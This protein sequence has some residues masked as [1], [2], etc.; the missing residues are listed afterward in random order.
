MNISICDHCGGHVSLG[1]EAS[2][3]CEVCGR[4][5]EGGDPVPPTPKR[6]P[7]KVWPQF[8]PALEDGSK[9]F[10]ARKDDRCFRVG[11]VLDLYGFAPLT[12]TETGWRQ[13]R[14]ITYKLSGPAW[15]VESGYC[16]LGL[17]PLPPVAGI[18]DSELVALRAEVARIGKE[19]E[20]LKGIERQ[21]WEGV[22]KVFGT[23]YPTQMKEGESAQWTGG[24]QSAAQWGEVAELK[25]ELESRRWECLE[26]QQKH[27]TLLLGM[28]K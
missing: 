3:C 20:V 15:G 18:D 5:A 19:V 22:N 6:H 26:W 11:D 23:K 25:K 21:R 7:L 10:E 13:S 2:N 4:S 28:K 9:T 24:G 1:H 8:I 27:D 12:S 14:V 16:I 17:S